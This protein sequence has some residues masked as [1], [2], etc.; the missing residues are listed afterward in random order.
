MTD[1]TKVTLRILDR[2][3]KEIVKLSRAESAVYDFQRTFRQNPNTPG[4]HFKRLRGNSRLATA[5]CSSWQPPGRAMTW[6]S[7]GTATPARSS[8]PSTPPNPGNAP[9]PSGRAETVPGPRVGTPSR[10]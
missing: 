3:D 8:L 2:A 6:R 7:S 9:T 4:L 1:Q 10:S 5:P